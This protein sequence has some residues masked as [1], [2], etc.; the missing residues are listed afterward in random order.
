MIDFEFRNATG[1]TPVRIGICSI[2]ATGTLMINANNLTQTNM[3][4]V[5]VDS[6]N[7][8]NT[9]HGGGVTDTNGWNNFNAASAVTET[10]AQKYDWLFMRVT[11]LSKINVIDPNV[12]SIGGRFLVVD[13]VDGRRVRQQQSYSRP[14]SSAGQGTFKVVAGDFGQGY[15]STSRTGDSGAGEHDLGRPRLAGGRVVRAAADEK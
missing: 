7:L 3:I 5:Y 8:A 15:G 2:W 9:A 1:T 13:D 11:D 6:W 14:M 4:K 10:A 12:G